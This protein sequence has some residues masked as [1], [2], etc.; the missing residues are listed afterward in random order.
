M[1]LPTF[2]ISHGVPDLPIRTGP[3]QDFLLQLL[4]TLPQRPTAILAI[5]AHWLTAQPTLSTTP[6]PQ[7]I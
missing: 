6:Q 4:A 2:F 5:S 3:T 7:T 1:T